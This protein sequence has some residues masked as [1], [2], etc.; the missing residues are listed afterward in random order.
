MENMERLD[1]KFW[2]NKKVLVTGHTGFKGAWASLI[3]NYLGCKV[4]A[5]AL[6]PKKN[7]ILFNQL[8]LQNIL[9]KSEF[10]NICDSKKLNK[11][12]L[13][14]KP[15]IIFHFAAQP[16]VIDSYKKPMETF[17]TN[18]LGTMNIL[19]LTKYKFVEFVT[20]ITSDKCYENSPT[21]NF[22]TENDK[23]GGNDIYSS[24]KACCELLVNAYRKSF[25]DGKRIITVRAGNVIGGGDFGNYRLM[26]DF[27]K[28]IKDKKEL[29]LR[30]PNYIRPWQHIFDVLNGYFLVTQ[31][32]FIKST[33]YSA[34]W[35]FGPEKNGHIKV[36][37]LIDLFN[38]KLDKRI[39][40]TFKKDDKY[41]E[42]KYLFLNI[43][44][45]K[46]ELAWRPKFKIDDVVKYTLD[47]YLNYFEKKKSFEFSLAQINNYKF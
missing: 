13:S 4:Y 23:L 3:L 1:R 21:K 38:E 39:N 6:K 47:W 41:P 2:K 40:V 19:N 30:N 33:K 36:S 44:R 8:N 18:V 17:N 5:C 15:E 46:K 28:C 12:I 10:F 34:A 27:F 42:E 32:C 11:F 7:Q 16:Y 31:K 43:S 22:F 45:S 37:T 24:S 26:T 25:C 20:I 14:T 9:E 35:N 29:K